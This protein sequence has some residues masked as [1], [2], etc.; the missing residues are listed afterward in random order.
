MRSLQS[1][2]GP[3][4]RHKVPSFTV[5]VY[6]HGACLCSRAMFERVQCVKTR[7]L[8]RSEV[9]TCS[10]YTVDG[11][12]TT[13]A[14]VRPL[15]RTSSTCVYKIVIFCTTYAW[16]HPSRARCCTRTYLHIRVGPK[17][18]P[19]E[20]TSIRKVFKNKAVADRSAF[21]LG[22]SGTRSGACGI[23]RIAYDPVGV[24]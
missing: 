15:D 4:H 17:D 14:D 23:A 9:V 21:C 18:E 24:G 11:S 1:R 6:G 5:P 2:R 7:I 22:P 20:P 8:R 12:R 16:T 13:I 10:Y 19:E 3:Y